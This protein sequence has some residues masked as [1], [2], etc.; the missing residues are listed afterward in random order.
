MRI[1]ALCLSLC[2][3]LSEPDNLSL[4]PTHPIFKSLDVRPQPVAADSGSEPDVRIRQLSLGR[5]VR[6]RISIIISVISRRVVL[7]VRVVH[8]GYVG[9]GA[10]VVGTV[11]RVWAAGAEGRRDQG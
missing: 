11:M 4:E 1:P 10:G 9:V 6:K 7:G 8:S 3:L 2:Q 5:R